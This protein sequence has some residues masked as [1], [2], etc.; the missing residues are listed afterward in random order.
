MGYGLMMD[1]IMFLS[2]LFVFFG[3][4]F[5][6]GVMFKLGNSTLATTIITLDCLFLLFNKMDS[7]DQRIKGLEEGEK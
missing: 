4:I 3:L 2:K 7:I 5:T 1:R 6:A